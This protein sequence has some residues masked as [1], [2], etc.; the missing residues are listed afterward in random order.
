MA[1]CADLAGKNAAIADVRGTG[2]ADL[3]AEQRVFSYFAGVAALH[4]IVNFRAAADLRLAD[5]GAVNGGVSLDFDVIADDGGARLTH[6]VPMAVRFAREAEAV[7]ADDHPVLQQDAMA[8]AAILANAGVGVG[9]EI[10]ADARAAINRDETVQDR[11]TTDLDVFVNETVGADVRAD[12][13]PGGACDDGRSVHARGV[14]RRGM[15]QLDGAGEI[16]I[17]VRRTKRGDALRL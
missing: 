10:V 9:E 1:S 15:E 4:E 7:A 2:K 17:R 13:D 16:E 6:F 11:V 14:V 3:A 8:E 12:S 5:R